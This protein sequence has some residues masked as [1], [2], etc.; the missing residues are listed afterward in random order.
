MIQIVINIWFKVTPLGLTLWC[1][2]N[3][4]ECD[5]HKVSG[6]IPSGVN[7]GGLV[8]RSGF[9]LGSTSGRLDWTPRINRSLGQILSFQ[10]KKKLWLKVLSSCQRFFVYVVIHNTVKDYSW[11]LLLHLQLWL[12]L[13]RKRNFDDTTGTTKGFLNHDSIDWINWL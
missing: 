7:F 12:W 11:V 1:W 4:L 13:H 9:K 5:P 2:L 3:T 6:S 8:H 10:K